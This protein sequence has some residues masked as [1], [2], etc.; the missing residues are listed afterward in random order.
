MQM[1]LMAVIAALLVITGLLGQ[2]IKNPALHGDTHA[3]ADSPAPESPYYSGA[4]NITV[5]ANTSM[6]RCRLASVEQSLV[7]VCRALYWMGT[8]NGC[9]PL[10]ESF[11]W[12]FLFQNGNAG[13]LN[14]I[15]SETPSSTFS[16]SNPAQYGTYLL[17]N[18][19]TTTDLAGYNY[20]L[21]NSAGT[22]SISGQTDPCA[23]ADIVYKQ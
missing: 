12:S 2:G 10:N 17:G 16:C 6:E 11:T 22:G 23:Y 4:G 18:L 13:T 14:N 19:Y 9:S 7:E 20:N 5:T 1:L 3:V 15:L 21:D 8:N